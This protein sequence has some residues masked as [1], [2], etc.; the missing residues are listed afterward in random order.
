MITLDPRKGSAY[1]SESV[2]VL[3]SECPH[4]FALRMERREAY[5]AGEAHQIR[6][7]GVP[8]EVADN[9]R[10]HWEKR[11]AAIS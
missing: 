5:L 10:T 9:A 6:V 2:L 4:W 3:C 1:T 8:V 11:H 7:H